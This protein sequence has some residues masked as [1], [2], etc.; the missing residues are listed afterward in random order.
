MASKCCQTQRLATTF[1]GGSLRD[2]SQGCPLALGGEL[3]RPRRASLLTRRVVAMA[4]L[5]AKKA[6]KGVWGTASRA[7]RP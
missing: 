4:P 3:R 5:A 2:F 7:R 6:G 1:F